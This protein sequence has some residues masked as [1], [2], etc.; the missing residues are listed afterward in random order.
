MPVYDYACRDC[1]EAFTKVLTIREY[2]QGGQK[3][4]KCG[5]ANIEQVPSSFF[6]VTAKKS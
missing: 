2:E 5:S 1:K 4:P 6:A 3:C